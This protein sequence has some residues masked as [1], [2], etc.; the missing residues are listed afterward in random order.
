[1]FVARFHPSLGR[2]EQVLTGGRDKKGRIWD[3]ETAS[4]SRILNGHTDAIMG[5]EWC[6]DNPDL[7]V[8]CS[9]DN[10]AKIWDARAEKKVYD[11]TQHQACVWSACWG[12]GKT[13]LTCSHDMT[14][15][16]YDFRKM[17]PEFLVLEGHAGILWQASFDQSQRWVVTCSEDTTARLWKTDLSSVDRGPP[18]LEKSELLQQFAEHEGGR[19]SIHPVSCAGFFPEEF[20]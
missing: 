9:L 16:I 13:L 12:P 7:V 17:E 8:T 11:I 3:I 19:K 18:T 4:A 10:T 2:T 15:A 1:V 20:S 6:R 5:A 14:A